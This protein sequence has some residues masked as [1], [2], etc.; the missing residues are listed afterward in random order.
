MSTPHRPPRTSRCVLYQDPPRG[1]LRANLVGPREVAITAGQSAFREH[2]FDPLREILV[3]GFALFPGGE[4][5]E[6]EHPV[7]AGEGV[8][9]SL[10][11]G[12]GDRDWTE[13]VETGVDS[14]DQV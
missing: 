13:L 12:L 3:D 14:G 9:R 5:E 1:E 11:L 2:G 7:D 4:R 6:S 10:G 8:E